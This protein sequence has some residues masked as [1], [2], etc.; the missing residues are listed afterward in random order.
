M[1]NKYVYL[2]LAL[3]ISILLALA[4]L[5]INKYATFENKNIKTLTNDLIGI[6]LIIID[7]YLIYLFSKNESTTK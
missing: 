6:A 1:K 7:S 3:I 2:I 4:L 5:F